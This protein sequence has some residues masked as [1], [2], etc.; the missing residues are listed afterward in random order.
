[1]ASSTPAYLG[2][3]VYAAFDGFQIRL[4]TTDGISETN[5]IF[6]DPEVQVELVRFIEKIVENG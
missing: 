2:D 3:G 1:M 5:V 4:W 6:L